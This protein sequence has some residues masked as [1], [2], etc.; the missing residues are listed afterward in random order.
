[1]RPINVRSKDLR[2]I[3]N[4]KT[5]IYIKQFLDRVPNRQVGGV[6]IDAIE[7]GAV[8]LFVEEGYQSNNPIIGLTRALQVEK[9][10]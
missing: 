7:R 3:I 1:M 2:M 8:K 5:R 10:S 4:Q 6:H 9:M